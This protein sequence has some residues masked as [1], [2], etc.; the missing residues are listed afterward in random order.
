MEEV[1]FSPGETIYK[2][3]R[4]DDCSFYYLVKGEVKIY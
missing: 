1:L 2:Q 3:D 4:L